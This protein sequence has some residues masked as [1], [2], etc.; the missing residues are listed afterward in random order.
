MAQAADRKY[1]LAP[2]AV[3]SKAFR[4][5]LAL[6]HYYSR[7]TQYNLPIIREKSCQSASS[8]GALSPSLLP[9]SSR[10]A[11]AWSR[12][13]QWHTHHLLVFAALGTTATACQIAAKGQVELLSLLLRAQLR[14]ASA[15]H[16][17]CEAEVQGLAVAAGSE[18]SF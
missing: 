8:S 1:S 15:G 12:V 11:P 16:A 17:T 6:L 3:L 2:K 7:A 13:R 10:A 5:T 4:P 18:S 9:C 14:P